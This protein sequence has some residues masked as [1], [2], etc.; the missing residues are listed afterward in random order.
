MTA[1]ECYVPASHVLPAPEHG[2]LDRDGFP[3]PHRLSGL[4]AVALALAASVIFGVYSG[5][6]RIMGLRVRAGG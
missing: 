1:P 2:N 4:Y 6:F 3:V 5:I